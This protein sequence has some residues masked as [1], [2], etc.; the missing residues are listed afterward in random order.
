[1]TKIEKALTKTV[2]TNGKLQRA[3][4]GGSPVRVSYS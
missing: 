4:V 1:M 2:E 3:G